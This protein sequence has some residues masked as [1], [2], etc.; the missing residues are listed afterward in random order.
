M[1]IREFLKEHENKFVLTVIGLLS[2]L[3]LLI[4]A[5]IKW[6]IDISTLEQIGMNIGI[7]VF[8]YSVI[9]VVGWLVDSTKNN[10]VECILRKY[11]DQVEA[12][13]ND[14]YYS[15][16]S[17]MYYEASFEGNEIWVI[18][19]NLDYEYSTKSKFVNVIHSNVKDRNIT[20]TYIVPNM[21]SLRPIVK[22]L[23]EEFQTNRPKITVIDKDSFDYP[24][25]ILVFFNP[26]AEKVDQRQTV[27]MEL[28][29]N[30]ELNKRGWAKIADNFAKTIVNKVQNDMQH[31]DIEFS[32]S[33]LKVLGYQNNISS[34]DGKGT[35]EGVKR[36]VKKEVKSVKRRQRP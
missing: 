30:I 32:A 5:L 35:D 9:I 14:W 8:V 1:K 25:D 6:L 21:P 33:D 13:E 26:R 18:S 10:Q 31:N 22:V 23:K 3:Y 7:M 28:K 12:L 16:D 29:V 20:Y 36:V 27:F 11:Q 2:S 4:N 15:M 24:S 19:E 34:Y 17:L